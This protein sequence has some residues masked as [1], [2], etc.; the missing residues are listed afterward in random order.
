M[1]WSSPTR[2][3]RAYHL[4][5][6]TIDER[7]THLG[8]PDGDFLQWVARRR[9]RYQSNDLHASPAIPIHSPAPSCASCVT[10]RGVVLASYVVSSLVI[11]GVTAIAVAYHFGYATRRDVGLAGA[12]ATLVILLIICIALR[13]AMTSSQ[14]KASPQ[15]YPPRSDSQR[16]LP[17]AASLPPTPSL[18]PQQSTP[19]VMLVA[20][21]PRPPDNSPEATR[22]GTPLEVVENVGNV[23]GPKGVAM[24]WLTAEMESP[25]DDTLSTVSDSPSVDTDAILAASRWRDPTRVEVRP[26]RLQTPPQSKSPRANMELLQH[27]HRLQHPGCY[28]DDR[29]MRTSASSLPHKLFE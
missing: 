19:L 17:A 16:A 24:A 28:T 8:E 20:V 9:A 18:R 3:P 12:L 13:R 29:T 21:A 26:K 27:S 25:C 14:L 11:L 1:I 22:P 4:L 10:M 23:A 5:S 6:G 15:V 7:S 2:E